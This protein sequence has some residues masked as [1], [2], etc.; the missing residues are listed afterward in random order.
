M[1]APDTNIEKQEKRH[2][3]ALLGIKGAALFGVLMVLILLF[4]VIDNGREDMVPE[5]SNS[6][7]ITS[8]VDPAASGSTI[9]E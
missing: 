3:P 7:I 9:S 1:S 4:F 8:P 2:K 5:A 6:E